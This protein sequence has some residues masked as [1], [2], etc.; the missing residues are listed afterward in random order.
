MNKKDYIPPEVNISTVIL[1]DFLRN[2][3]DPIILP[4]H[5]FNVY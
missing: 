2:S 3:D 4:P 5:E 1:E